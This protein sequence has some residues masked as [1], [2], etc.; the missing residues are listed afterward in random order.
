M[1]KNSRNK[2]GQFLVA[3]ALLFAILFISVASLLSS[4]TITDVKLL[5]DDFRK[6][7]MQI[8]SNFR[9]AL[10]LALSKVTSELELSP[11]NYSYTMDSLFSYMIMDGEEMMINWQNTILQQY[12]GRSIN[13]SITNLVFKCNWNSSV[14][15]SKV[16]ATM[17]LDIRSYGF[18]GLKQN[19]S[20]ELTLQ[21]LGRKQ[22]GDEVVIIIKVQKEKG[23]P[24]TDLKPS[25]TNILYK[26]NGSLE[27]KFI[28][29]N[30]STLDLI[31]LGSGVY[32]VTFSAP[33]CTQP[34]MIKMILQDGR[35]IVVAAIQENGTYISDIT[36]N[37]GPITTNVLCNPNPCTKPSATK[38]TA[39]I[40]DTSTGANFIISAEYFIDTK[41]GN[42]SGTPMS[43]SD[44]YFDSTLEN[45]EAQLSTASLSSG[46]HTI[47]VHGMDAVGNW[48]NFGSV[49][50]TVTETPPPPQTQQK[51]HIS[52]V[53]VRA[54]PDWWFYIHGIA[55][56]T[57]VD[58]DGKHVSGAKVYGHWSGSVS[59]SV[60]GY[61]GT[62]GK[63]TFYSKDVYYWRGW[64]GWGSG[65]LI[66][67]FTVDNIE[68][69]DWIYDE[70]VNVETSD[71]AYYP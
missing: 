62:N 43:V 8:I 51:M 40:D 6:D 32:N 67:T 48:G 66:F 1:T 2:K 39:T 34:A 56:V 12:A 5:K 14:F 3:S 65:K 71:T 11:Y 13:L 25:F 33:D 50:L 30:P 41:T 4:T 61:T 46:N 29:V 42:G 37:V 58:A 22:V 31:Y 57:I 54:I 44:G 38:L 64:G 47:Y 59:G 45:V 53:S 52:D 55:T 68:K 9:G 15:Y 35:G 63:V 36:D 49:V 19:V 27:N 18:Y 10:A 70:S 69:T 24:V 16:N 28:N 7:A 60:Y 17:T 20:S 21:F 23:L 26:I